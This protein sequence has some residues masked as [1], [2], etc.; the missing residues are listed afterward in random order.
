MKSNKKIL[1]N[2]KRFLIPL[3]YFNSVKRKLTKKSFL[4]KRLL[5][6]ITLSAPD[7]RSIFAS[8]IEWMPPPEAI[9]TK[10]LYEIVFSVSIKLFVCFSFLWVSMIVVQSSMVPIDSLM[11]KMS[12]VQIY[13]CSR[14][15]IYICSRNLLLHSYLIF[16]RL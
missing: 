1:I 4:S 7:L 5:F 15:L 14:N 3:G 16:N 6:I 10:H 13:I 9:G 12:S 2:K 8:L 11:V